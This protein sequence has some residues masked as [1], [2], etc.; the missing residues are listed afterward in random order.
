MSSISTDDGIILLDHDIKAAHIW[1]SFKNWIGISEKPHTTQLIGQYIQPASHIDFSQLE[2]P[3]TVTEMDGI[4]KHMPTD[5]SP[6]PDGFN[7][8][9]LKKHWNIVKEQFYRLCHDFHAGNSNI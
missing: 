8:A 1:A 7:G 3:F 2:I 5:K 6:G 4:V 9:F